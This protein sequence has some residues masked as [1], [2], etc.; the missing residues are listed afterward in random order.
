VTELLFIQ[1]ANHKTIYTKKSW[2]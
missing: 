2:W 1:L